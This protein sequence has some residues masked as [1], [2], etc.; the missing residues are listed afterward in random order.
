MGSSSGEINASPYVIAAQLHGV[1]VIPHIINAVILISVTSV[2]IAAMYSSP[3][4]LQSLADQGLAP[5]YFNYV[6]KHGRP[7]RAWVLTIIC[8][9]FSYIAAFEHQ[10]IVFNWLLSISGVSFVFVW[11]FICVCHLRFRAALKHRN[12]PLSSLAY[13]APTGII[14]SWLSIVVN[15]L[16]LVGQFWV[17]LFP[18]GSDRADANNFFQNYLGVPVLFI[19]YFAHKLWTKNWKLYKR[20]DEIDLDTGMVYYDPEILELEKL[21][22]QQRFKNANFLKKIYIFCLD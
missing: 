16:M 6:D 18:I 11:M 21:E 20:V 17:A 14:G 3:R 9:F 10:D 5:K 8:T 4:L 2:A 15:F 22:E 12:I 13:V 1:M 19:L 7:L